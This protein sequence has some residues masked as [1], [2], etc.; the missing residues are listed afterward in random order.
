METD[1]RESGD[2]LW[3][4]LHPKHTLSRSPR[5]YRRSPNGGLSS[6][7]IG[8]SRVRSILPFRRE[9]DIIPVRPS[10]S[11][12]LPPCDF[13]RRDNRVLQVARCLRQIENLHAS[14]FRI[15]DVELSAACSKTGMRDLDCRSA[16]PFDPLN[17]VIPT[18]PLENLAMREC[19]TSATRRAVGPTQ[20]WGWLVDKKKMAFGP[21][22][23][24]FR[25]EVKSQIPSAVNFCT[26]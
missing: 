17:Q 16:L 8:V 14:V 19:R 23:P 5:G 11:T 21:K 20:T 4:H 12:V 13:E 24:R 15:G 10:A 3:Y 25:A 2:T 18:L 26:R 22:P 9:R 1:L 7:G 6:N